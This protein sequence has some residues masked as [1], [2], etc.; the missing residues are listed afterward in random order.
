VNGK[1]VQNLKDLV[2]ILQHQEKQCFVRF[3]L[4]GDRSIVLNIESVNTR[5]DDILKRHKIGEW[6][7]TKI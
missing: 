2:N 6:R 7:H 5:Q 4:K 3:D 1:T